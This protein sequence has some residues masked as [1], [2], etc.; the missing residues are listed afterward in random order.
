MIKSVLLVALG[1]GLGSVIR[2]FISRVSS[3][4]F[5]G[6]FPLG[7][8][9]CNM[10]GCLLIGFFLALSEKEDWLSPSIR[11]F[12]TVGFCG[13]FT[14]FSTFMNENA[15]L[16]KTDIPMTFLYTGGS[17]LLGFIMVYIGHFLVKLL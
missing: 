13:G 12:L 10:G 9:I 7:T 16:A 1:G 14:T 11:L 5:S 4:F 2:F 17:L 3:S 6:N 8:F 15:Q